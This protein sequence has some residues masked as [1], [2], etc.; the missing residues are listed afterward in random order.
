MRLL[1]HKE[2]YGALSIGFHWIMV[3]LLVAVYATM[4][5]SGE[6]PKGSDSRAALKSWHYMLGLT[7]FGLVWL[8]LAVNLSGTRPFIEPAPP[9]L[10]DRLARL[11]QALFYL[12]MVLMPLAGW[13]ILSA[14]GQPILFF[15][16]PLP[17]LMAENKGAAGW[18]KDVHEAG[19][20]AGYIL[21][22]LHAGAAL[23]HH[24]FV[25][26][27]TLQRMLPGRR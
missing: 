19:A 1:N 12:L 7:V 6:F 5:F 25:H 17:A 21:V 18:I 23:F 10:Q 13:L 15:G 16:L 22:G 26:D 4:E 8:R 2:R 3:L 14:R 20:T 11:V 27:N 24:Y 9:L